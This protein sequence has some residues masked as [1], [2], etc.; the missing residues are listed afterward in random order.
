MATVYVTL[1]Q[2]GV[3]GAM[4]NQPVPAGPYRS[5]TITSSATSAAGAL[6]S[7]RGE[8]ATVFCSTALYA[9]SGA[10]ASPSAGKYIPAGVLTEIALQLGHVLHVIDV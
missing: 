7:R 10:T 1:Q 2:A 5:E 6:T 4:G 9:N 3:H 8:V